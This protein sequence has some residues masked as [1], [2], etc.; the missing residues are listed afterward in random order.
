MGVMADTQLDLF[1]ERPPEANPSSPAMPRTVASVG[2]MADNDLLSAMAT[3]GMA[4][5]KAMAEEVG[6]RKLRDAV[7]S[8]ES[9]CRRFAGFGADALIAEQAVALRALAAIG[10]PGAA[11]CVSRLITRKEVQGPTLAIAVSAAAQLAARLPQAAL[12]ELLRAGDPFVRADACRCALPHVD[13][14]AVLFDLMEDLNPVVRIAATCAL[15]RMGRGEVRPDLIRLLE[16]SPSVEMIE[17]ITAIADDDVVVLL[18]RLAR[19]QPDLMESVLDS[20]ESCAS[21]LA[22]RVIEKLQREAR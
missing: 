3:A 1:S 8:L 10:G 6:R 14:V 13:I 18:G 22:T 20:L 9:I 11:D 16:R 17:A 4:D 12:L 5:L 19:T 7:K 2:D 15:G 21:P